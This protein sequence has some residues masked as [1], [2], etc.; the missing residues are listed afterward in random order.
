MGT[1]SWAI[2]N[3]SNKFY[4]EKIQWH[5]K[6]IFKEATGFLVEYQRLNVAQV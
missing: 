1:V 2:W 6:N 5:L 3:A 4:L